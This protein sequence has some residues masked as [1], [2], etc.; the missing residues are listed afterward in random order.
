ML[1]LVNCPSDQ[2]FP[3]AWTRLTMNRLPVICIVFCLA[4]LAG[5]GSATERTLDEAVQVTKAINDVLDGVKTT[6]AARAAVEKLKPLIARSKDVAQR[7]EKIVNKD[8]EN[9]IAL[10]MNVADQLKEL[11][12][13]LKDNAHRI[14][15][16][17]ELAG[18]LSALLK[19]MNP[20]PGSSAKPGPSTTTTAKD[21]T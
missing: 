21:A 19:E 2:S 11:S 3:S 15:A 8:P 1:I 14:M 6:A 4:L 10:A 13:K 17:P 18:P 5:C 9:A 7:L 20:P 12:Q 16:N